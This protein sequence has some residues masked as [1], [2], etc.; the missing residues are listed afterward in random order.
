[1][2]VER[3]RA[4]VECRIECCFLLQIKSQIKSQE[5]KN[6]QRRKILTN[7]YNLIHGNDL[8][9]YFG[10]KTPTLKAFLFPPPP[11]KEKNEIQFSCWPKCC[12]CSYIGWWPGIATAAVPWLI[13]KAIRSI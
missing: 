7:G 12:V 6:N 4:R 2:C 8:Y 9:S 1:M 10:I 3:E 11:Y 5:Y 13:A